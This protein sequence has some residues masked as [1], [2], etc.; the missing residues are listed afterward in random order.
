MFE[1]LRQYCMLGLS[2]WRKLSL[3]DGTEG[4]KMRFFRE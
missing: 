3:G 1:G 4:S 2:G